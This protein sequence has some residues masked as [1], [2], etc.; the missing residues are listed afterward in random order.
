LLTSLLRAATSTQHT[1][2]QDMRCPDEDV[3]L[4]WKCSEGRRG[5]STVKH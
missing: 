5:E 2:K 4:T 1:R 3:R